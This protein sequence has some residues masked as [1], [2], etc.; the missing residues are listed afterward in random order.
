MFS[1]CIVE[2]FICGIVGGGEM[3]YLHCIISYHVPFCNITASSAIIV[4]WHFPHHNYSLAG[5]G[6]CMV[7]SGGK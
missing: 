4:M 7:Q 1:L 5:L 3:I 2:L 6:L